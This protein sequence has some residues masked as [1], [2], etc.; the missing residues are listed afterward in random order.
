[1]ANELISI[2]ENAGLMG[3]PIPA[4]ITKAIAVL[5]SKSEDSEESEEK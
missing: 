1:M 3:I 5:K 2:T 4:V